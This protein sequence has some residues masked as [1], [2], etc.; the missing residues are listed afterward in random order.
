MRPGMLGTAAAV[1]MVLL[2]LP[3][4]GSSY[5]SARICRDPFRFNAR[6]ML[7]RLKP[8]KV[9]TTRKWSVADASTVI[10]HPAGCGPVGRKGTGGGAAGLMTL[11]VSPLSS[12][13]EPSEDIPELLLTLD[14]SES[15][16]QG[17]EL[18]DVIEEAVDGLAADGGI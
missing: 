12:C 1:V 13:N 7:S 3:M 11:S 18:L 2:L 14:A 5:L 8:G 10:L 9:A 6:V 15:L 16:T 4:L 17:L